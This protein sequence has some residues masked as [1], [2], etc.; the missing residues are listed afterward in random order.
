MR[1][2][3]SKNYFYILLGFVLLAGI[4]VRLS[5]DLLS[6]A[7]WTDEIT[8]YKRALKG[9][10][11]IGLRGPLYMLVTG[12]FY[13]HIFHGFAEYKV[14]FLSIGSGIVFLP[15][16]ALIVHRIFKDKTIT[17][18]TLLLATVNIGLIS[19]SH[20]AKPY[21]LALLL[22]SLWFFSLCLWSNR[23]KFYVGTT[24]FLAV[25]SY[26][27]FGM[28]LLYPV[29]FLTGLF[30][31][32]KQ[33]ITASRFIFSTA[34]QILSGSVFVYIYIFSLTQ[35]SGKWAKKYGVFYADRFGNWYSWVLE[36][37]SS[38][39]SY[40]LNYYTDTISLGARTGQRY[41]ESQ[42]LGII[43]ILLL[44]W[45]IYRKFKTR[46]METEWVI[47][48]VILTFTVA[49]LLKKWP[50]GFF[51]TNIFFYLYFSLFLVYLIPE[52]IRKA[53]FVLSVL[54]AVSF[55]ISNQFWLK[56]FGKQ[57][58]FKEYVDLICRKHS[59]YQEIVA[60]T[61]MIITMF[62]YQSGYVLN[63]GSKGIFAEC[64]RRVP[65][66]HKVHY[67]RDFDKT[68]QAIADQVVRPTRLWFMIL[69]TAHLR[70]DS[71]TITYLQE[72]YNAEL[73]RK[74]DSDFLLE[75]QLS[76]K[77]SLPPKPVRQKRKSPLNEK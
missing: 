45:Y 19:F 27:S 10:H 34:I 24:L 4:L 14:R 26:F 72:N 5:P 3:F 47:I 20:E 70:D 33:S 63:E 23:Y 9:Q 69:G 53:F 44:V 68:T 65:R 60:D 71:Q 51:R 54:T 36:R 52:K 12:F 74:S 13:N 75:A 76:P 16:Y 31:L 7:L 56:K 32:K 46:P 40:I 8:W 17:L 67:I 6:S 64:G 50:F 39:F 58:H 41:F 28:M 73:I 25:S 15:L 38:Y 61:N 48:G 42:W 1:Q 21:S 57:N 43:I 77:N 29:H 66:L 35:S 49:G 55:S 18:C 2:F 62:F 22:H 59:Y 30:W 37:L 11:I